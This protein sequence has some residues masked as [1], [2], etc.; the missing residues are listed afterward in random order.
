MI[1][2]IF[3]LKNETL[4]FIND[5]IRRKNLFYFIQNL[6]KSAVDN[7]LFLVCNLFDIINHLMC[8]CVY[9]S[10]STL[11]LKSSIIFCSCDELFLFRSFLNSSIFSFK[12]LISF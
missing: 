11:A 1:L 9:G 7:A 8:W 4:E 10:F 12:L 5:L 3:K 2:S 6:F